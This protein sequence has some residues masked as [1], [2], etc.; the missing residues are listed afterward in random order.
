MGSG[1]SEGM[2]YSRAPGLS[3][4]ILCLMVKS[5][6]STPEETKL[7]VC[8]LQKSVWSSYLLFRHIGEVGHGSC[9][10]VWDLCEMSLD[11]RVC[12]SA[13]APGLRLVPSCSGSEFFLICQVLQRILPLSHV[14]PLEVTWPPPQL[15]HILTAPR[16]SQISPGPC[17][18]SRRDGVSQPESPA[19]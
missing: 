15:A 10:S 17:V 5:D 1:N 9:C 11:S 2:R 7:L 19:I 8:H 12:V 14:K 3:L 18:V 16:S 4:I 13:R 6:T